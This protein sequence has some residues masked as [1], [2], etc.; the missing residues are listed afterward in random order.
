MKKLSLTLSSPLE[1]SYLIVSGIIAAGL[2]LTFISFLRLC[3]EECSVSHN[4]RLFG[5]PFEVFGFIFFGILAITHFFANKNSFLGFIE[6]LLFASAIGA[7]GMFIIV[8]KYQIGIWCPVCL[9]IASII[10][11]GTIVQG[12]AYIKQ[13]PYTTAENQRINMKT[14]WNRVAPFAAIALGFLVAF[15]GITKHDELQAAQ[16]AIKD[17]IAFGSSKSD[18]EIYLFTDWACPACRKLE[19]TLEKLAPEI[20]QNN[21]FYFVDH[22]IHPETLNFI[23]YNLS[24]MLNNKPEYFRLRHM[25]G[26]ISKETST[27]TEDQVTKGAAKLGV[28][29][30]ELNYADIATGTKYFKSLGEKFKI[31]GTPTMILIN[32]ETKK[33]KKLTGNDEITKENIL[34]SINT[35]K[36][37]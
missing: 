31:K 1:K 22:V 37:S 23:P 24:F 29:F 36:G 20:M 16:E 6:L 21:Q 7:E 26:E 25:L 34:K 3:S 32:K 17:K 4:Y 12:L 5:M 11:I 2:I 10:L 30:H 14:I 9:T 15:F 27:P 8:Q 33:G 35:L 19:P 18:I 28:T 13:N